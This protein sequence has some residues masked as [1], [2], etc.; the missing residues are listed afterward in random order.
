MKTAIA[1]I[2]ILAVVGLLAMA[3]SDRP[4]PVDESQPTPAPTSTPIPP[5]PTSSVVASDDFTDARISMR[6]GGGMLGTVRV[7]TVDS[8][9]LSYKGNFLTVA[10]QEARTECSA[11]TISPEDQKL[12]WRTLY[13]SDV[14]T[15]GDNNEML[16]VV[17]DV[18]FYAII[19]EH[20]GQRNEFSYAPGFLADRLEGRYLAIVEAVRDLANLRLRAP[21]PEACADYQ[22]ANQTPEPTPTP[23]PPTSTPVDAS[24]A[25]PVPTSTPVPPTPKPVEESQPISAPTSTPV[26]PRP[27]PMPN[28]HRVEIGLGESVQ[29]PDQGIGISFDEVVEDSLC[30]GNVT[31]IWAGKAVIRLTVTEADTSTEVLLSLE[32][33]SPVSSPWIRVASH[34]TE[35]KA[36]EIRLIS[37]EQYPGADDDKDGV[38]PTAVLE[39]MVDEG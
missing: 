31:C 37:L 13:E 34:Q 27:T 26:P 32:P 30:R 15:L 22:E 2:T 14:F 20:D 10:N 6:E 3:C 19:V 33:D 7:H 1:I 24:Q 29:L 4:T 21:S 17:A 36:L 25:I 5:T 28:V 16:S 11:T 39:V 18:S 9:L 35:S 38:T 23:V 8:T 12:L